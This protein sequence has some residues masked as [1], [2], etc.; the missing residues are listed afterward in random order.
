MVTHFEQEGYKKGSKKKG[1]VLK[2]VVNTM[3]GSVQREVK[4]SVYNS[5][6][7]K[8]FINSFTLTIHIKLAFLFYQDRVVVGRPD[9]DQLPVDNTGQYN[10]INNSFI[11]TSSTVTNTSN[12]TRFSTIELNDQDIETIS[13]VNQMDNDVYIGDDIDDDVNLKKNESQAKQNE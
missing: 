1:K 7:E 11:T 5:Y 13:Q 8:V 12:T 10:H 2:G 6:D 3:V 4:L 9:F